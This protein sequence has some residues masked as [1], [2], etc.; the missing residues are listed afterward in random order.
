[1]KP[2]SSV[3]FV[4]GG[5]LIPALA[6]HGAACSRKMMRE[7]ERSKVV[8]S[9]KS[10]ARLKHASRCPLKM[11]LDA[12]E[13]IPPSDSSCLYCLSSLEAKPGNFLVVFFFRRGV[14]LCRPQRRFDQRGHVTNQ[15]PPGWTPKES[16]IFF[17]S[18]R[19]W[20]KPTSCAAL[21]GE[22]GSH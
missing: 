5:P 18:T 19:K 14:C 13:G 4:I 6:E 7:E 2:L 11:R 21:A 8:E 16:N 12:L 10:M 15:R 3:R 20:R 17:G 1:M 22:G 9:R